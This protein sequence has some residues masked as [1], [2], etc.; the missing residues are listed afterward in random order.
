MRIVACLP[1]LVG[2]ILAAPEEEGEKPDPR[3]LKPGH[4]PTPYTA[5]EIRKGC[6]EGR[7]ST[8]R[9]EI[10]GKDAFRQ[11]YRFRNCDDEGAD[12]ETVQTT[13]DGKPLKEPTKSRG[14]WKQ[15][16][17]H[18]LYPEAATKITEETLKTPAGSFACL[19][20]TVTVQAPDGK[21]AVMRLHFAKTLAG[22]PV[23]LVREVD[24]EAVF[25]MTLIHHAVEPPA[26]EAKPADE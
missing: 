2:L 3:R 12:L 4:A 20:Y 23:K 6:P 11:T 26:K 18:A 7:V 22:P 10:P 5:E 13:E 17:E 1:F 8:Y 14:T 19:L 9:I 21:T 25:T 24:G 16:Q 15:F